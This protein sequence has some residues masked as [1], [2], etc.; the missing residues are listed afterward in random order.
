M[1]G[2]LIGPGKK[3]PGSKEGK[4]VPTAGVKGTS[5]LIEDLFFNVLTRKNALR[6]PS[7]EYN[8]ILQVWLSE[9]RKKKKPLSHLIVP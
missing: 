3:A 5:I 6:N 1:D 7:D 2:G 4:P 8:R 9:E